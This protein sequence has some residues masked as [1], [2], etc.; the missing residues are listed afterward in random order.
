MMEYLELFIGVVFTT[1]G[2]LFGLLLVL[3]I[4]HSSKKKKANYGQR[5]YHKANQ[6]AYQELLDIEE[7]ID[8]VT[9]SEVSINHR[10]PKCQGLLKQRLGKEKE[11][12]TQFNCEC[13]QKDVRE[14]IESSRKKEDRAYCFIKHRQKEKKE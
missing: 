11:S 1:G 7:D 4:I 9:E 12:W 10:K 5:T 3:Q 13:D 2:V 8:M 14:H 6:K